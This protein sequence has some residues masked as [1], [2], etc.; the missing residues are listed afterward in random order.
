MAHSNTSDRALA[1]GARG[2]GIVVTGQALRLAIQ[3]AGT[4]ILSRLLTPA[5]F[6]LIAMV[7]VFTSLG[8]LLRD[9]GVSTVA[10][11]AR[12]LTQQQASNLFWL[13]TVLS[14]TV[15]ATLALCTPLLVILYDEPRLSA[16]GPL[17]ALGLLLDGIQ[18]PLH[19]RL[20]RSMNFLALSV[21]DIASQLAALV[22]AI[23]AAIAGW[24]YWALVVQALAASLLLLVL[25]QLVAR[26]VPSWPR[27]GHGSRAHFRAGGEFGLA[28]LLAFAANNTDTLVAGA[29][30]GAVDLG[31]YSRAFQL[32]ALPRIGLI[33]PLTQVAIPTVNAAATDDRSRVNALLLRIQ[34]LLSMPL[35]LIY[36]IAAATADWLIPLVLGDQWGAS[37]LPFQLLTIGGAFVAFSS[38]SYW[39][40]VVSLQSRQLM[41]LHLVTKPMAIIFIVIASPFGINAIALAYALGLALAWPINLI[42]LARTAGQDSWAFFRTG[43]RVLF[44]GAVAFA[45]ARSVLVLMA[46]PPSFVAIIVGTLTATI[47][48]LVAI[49]VIPGGLR[50]IVEAGRNARMIFR[51]RVAVDR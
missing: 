34:F 10:L 28:Q 14:A 3:L 20:A 40:F 23:L 38:V 26:W 22:L 5:D 31:Y 41:L 27:R 2:G 47:A 46:D 4:V 29:R 21:T 7:F 35:T 19:M 15:A 11:Q 33:D 6:G 48:F 8:A 25:R 49:V 12:T 1:T 44:S 16:I 9:F 36:V 24:G 51:R 37:V 43:L 42:W 45:A 30:W 13:S 32:Y 39:M 50:L 17:L 18:S